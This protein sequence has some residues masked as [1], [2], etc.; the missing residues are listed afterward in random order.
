[1]SYDEQN[2]KE[3]N[4]TETEN[5]GLDDRKF[6]LDKS[7]R[8]LIEFCHSNEKESL[9]R[10][11]QEEKH[12]IESEL[13]AQKLVIE[14]EHRRLALDVAD[15]KHEID[16]LLKKRE[17]LEKI[18][19][20][21]DTGTENRELQIQETEVQLKKAKIELETIRSEGALLLKAR[22][23]IHEQRKVIEEN[24]AESSR[25]VSSLTNEQLQIASEI[26][27]FEA[28]KKT[29]ADEYSTIKPLVE[30]QR[31]TLDELNVVLN[32][33]RKELVIVTEQVKAAMNDHS[34]QRNELTKMIEQ[35]RLSMDAEQHE[36]LMKQE[37]RLSE[38]LRRHDQ[39]MT[40]IRQNANLEAENIIKGARLQA[41]EILRQARA[42]SEKSKR[43][44]EKSGILKQLEIEAAQSKSAATIQSLQASAQI[45]IAT[46]HNEAKRDL[47]A[48]AEDAQIR[49]RDLLMA[50][51]DFS[52]EVKRSSQSE[53]DTLLRTAQQESERIKRDA[54][55]E[56]AN[57]RSQIDQ[58]VSTRRR[59]LAQEIETQRKSVEDE[60]LRLRE[61]TSKEV[62]N[63]RSSTLDELSKIRSETQNELAE[64][65]RKA[66]NEIATIDEQ[67]RKIIGDAQGSA[68]DTEDR[69]ARE[70]ERRLDASNKAIQ[71]AELASQNRIRTQEQEARA[72]IVTLE[73]D[74]RA[75]RNSLEDETKR[76]AKQFRETTL[77]DM[78]LE[79]AKFRAETE[80]E[81]KEKRL[82]F[83]NQL[84]ND[85][86]EASLQ[87]ERWRSEIEAHFIETRNR[88]ATQLV[89]QLQQAVDVYVEQALAEQKPEKRLRALGSE[90]RNLAADIF[91]AEHQRTE[92]GAMA[93]PVASPN[94]SHGWRWL[95]NT[96]RGYAPAVVVLVALIAGGSLL[97]TKY[98]AAKNLKDRPESAAEVEAPAVVLKAPLFNPPTTPEAKTTYTD[99]VI[100]TTD[101]SR[102]YF[103]GD[104]QKRWVLALSEFIDRKLD[105]DAQTVVKIIPREKQLLRRLQA[106]REKIDPE[107][108][109]EEMARMRVVESEAAKDI[110]E[111]LGSKDNYN[112]FR[113]FH[114]DFFEQFRKDPR[115][116]AGSGSG[117]S[118]QNNAR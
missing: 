109:N 16:L 78:D 61:Q 56:V 58:E 24:L 84:E 19:S 5:V 74:S 91:I 76:W 36:L 103:R 7:I 35:M 8:T 29:L 10:Y 55:Q 66:E 14:A 106:M 9:S 117:S 97:R 13:A 11:F 23:A 40:E 34:I 2:S 69:A 99:D 17:T 111:H 47:F 72:K 15:L 30:E 102:I 68:R 63:L 25:K 81:L 28:Q 110:S 45:E 42:D 12:R 100:S 1:M 48:K 51:Q 96:L 39:R 46:M 64:K 95:F 33:K 115:P 73:E 53:A 108:A 22:E 18:V 82:A 38:N 113:S 21:N 27:L 60:L 112:R 114:R 107:K 92:A 86:K 101:Y 49:A 37:E 6:A 98:M 105:R 75:K 90:V 3:L 104:Y 116:N 83:D 4:P 31:R 32:E 88:V 41:E 89:V 118:P 87:L 43:E 67:V 94:A 71:A 59:E 52:D 77:K 62:E 57:K 93:Q 79:Q 65:R 20:H 70:A 85:K 26:K 50:A 54:N 44:S 80:T